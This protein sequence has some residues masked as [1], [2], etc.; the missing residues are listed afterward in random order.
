MPTPSQLV[1]VSLT[2][3]T[4]GHRRSPRLAFLRL[5]PAGRRELPAIDRIKADYDRY[6]NIVESLRQGYWAHNQ[7]LTLNLR[8]RRSASMEHYRERYHQAF[9]L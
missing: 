5:S 9:Q 3:L 6:K 8:L 7:R 2:F 1:T 4:P